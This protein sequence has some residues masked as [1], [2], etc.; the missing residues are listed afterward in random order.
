[1]KRCIALLTAIILC[2][3]TLFVCEVAYAAVKP[4]KNLVTDGDMEI[5]EVPTGWAISS[6]SSGSTLEIVDDDVSSQPN[7]V[8][9]FDGTNNSGSIS[10]IS[11]SATVK[12]GYYYSFKIRQAT[13]DTNANVYL[14]TKIN[15]QAKDDICRPKLKK[16]EWTTVSG[17]ADTDSRVLSFKM[18]NDQASSTS[19][20][21]KVIYEIDDVV[22]CDMTDAVPFEPVISYDGATL[23][24]E[25]GVLEIN[26]TSYVR[27]DSDISFNVT[28]PFG[29]EIESVT[30][31]GEEIESVDGL[32]TI[33]A[34]SVGS[35]CSINITA[36]A[37]AGIPHI[38]SISPENCINMDPEEAIVTVNFDRDVD[39]DTLTD[40][41]I[42]VEPEASF[43]VEEADEDYAY[44][45]VFDELSEGTE[46]T[47]TF[48]T[49]IATDRLEALEQDYEYN[50]T[51][52]ETKN[53]IENSDM[54]EDTDLY[55]VNADN[56]PS[57]YTLDGNRV[58]CLKAGWENAPINQY[59][60]G[61]NRTEKY[62]FLPGHRYYTEAKVYAKSDIK[63][64]WRIIYI[65]ETDSSTVTHPTSISW[66]NVKAGEWTDVSCLFD[67]IPSNV[68]PT[69]RGYAVR[70]IAKADSY[71]VDVYIDDWG[72]YDC[73][74]A[75]AGKP[76][77]ISST[78]EDGTTNIEPG[79][80][81]VK[82]EFNKPMLP[83]SAKNIKVTNAEVKNIKFLD[84]NTTCIVTLDKI[85]VN[86]T[87]EMELEKLSSLAGVEMEKQVLSFETK[88]INTD[89]PVLTI[90]PDGTTKTHVNGLTMEIKSNLPLEGPFDKTSFTT[91]PENL[92]EK[93]TWSDAET[94]TINVVFNQEVLAS[95][96]NYSITLLPTIKSQA[97]T[98]IN[99]T[100]INFQTMTIAETV[101]LYKTI[102]TGNDSME[103]AKFLKTNYR[104]LNDCDTLSTEVIH[105]DN[106]LL[107]KFTAKLIS[108]T[109]SVATAEEISDKVWKTALL[110]I[111]NETNNE[112][113]IRASVESILNQSDKTGLAYT[114][115]N[116][117]TQT[118]KD[119]LPRKIEQKPADFESVDNY[120]YFV[121]ENIILNAFRNSNG[122]ETVSN[123]FNKNKD[124]FKPETKT[125]IDHVNASVY[126]E[127]IYG[128]LQGMN[129]A[130][131]NE[132]YTKLKAASE[133]DY[134][135]G[136]SGGG[137]GGS[138][139]GGAGGSSGGVSGG[140]E[141]FVVSAPAEGSNNSD[142]GEV[143]EVFKDIIS[144]PWAKEA[145]EYLY[146]LKVINGKTEDMFCPEDLVK[147]EEFVK[148]IV[149]AANIPLT[150]K[151]VKYTDVLESDWFYPY[152]AAASNCGLIKG[153]DKN[154]YGA[155][156]N[157]TRQDIAVLCSR[158]LVHA[159]EP[160]KDEIVSFADQT[161]ISDY[162]VKAVE[163]VAYLGLIIGNEKFEFSPKEYATRAET[164]VILQRLV[165]L[166][167]QYSVN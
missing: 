134:S 14:Y 118:I 143:K 9:R 21:S 85:K 91:V 122:W 70:L 131:E 53:L 6:S 38:V 62:E 119:E 95:G 45:L 94:D 157:I 36:K 83:S 154:T 141:G 90:T 107:G 5:D 98:S 149:I 79:A 126:K 87:I 18:I 152:V 12:S 144:V 103:L 163:K 3:Q 156:Q 66:I 69:S 100:T 158:L 51:T 121:E 64:A 42:L 116:Y 120:I 75:P 123:I 34:P 32:Y 31:N 133:A 124:F 11:H 82:L 41:N 68:C 148:M 165:A 2:M 108:E 84:G 43:V 97:G 35:P 166:L 47:L 93:V 127:Q 10:Y 159:D 13:D 23:R 63:V 61:E 112:N 132:A 99:E 145:I 50:F 88:S 57:Y 111:A 54:S 147:R 44:N 49:G 8:L 102:V 40:E 155:G 142:V 22:I 29:Y 4:L 105:T 92:I 25:S 30:V 19:N 80:L 15:A 109:G 48:T 89:P 77:L 139:G 24:W 33:T 78:P 101:D 86:R 65:T 72:L 73:S 81:D 128:N 164:A 16:G 71:P 104:D 146:D 37:D 115:T 20:V 138:S 151:S 46:Y 161:E 130:N 52:A 140:G 153:M 60:N 150:D 74:V 17:I 106:E 136:G 160:L 129:V 7:K 96:E 56:S 117:L 28:A 110:T 26:G 167:N 67:K 55:Y 114:Y 162:A 58:L 113:V 137:L 125:L 59:V 27:A 135:G 1:M 39:I 76:E